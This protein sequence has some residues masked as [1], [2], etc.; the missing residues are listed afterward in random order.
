M[1]DTQYV[2]PDL[3]TS[4]ASSEFKSK[5]RKKIMKIAIPVKTDKENPAIAPLFGKAKWFAF[6]ED[7]NVNI[8]KSPIQEG[9]AAIEWLI[10]EGVDTIIMQ[11]MGSG[12]YSM[13]RAH[14]GI[15]LYHSGYE[16]IT[17]DLVLKKFADNALIKLDET[18]IDEIIAHHEGKHSHGDQHHHGE[19]HTHEHHHH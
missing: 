4:T 16:R 15:K 14:G 7:N 9:R 13:I 1:S 8:M 6:I 10:R 12:P 17:L 5:K 11:E 3:P 18:N 2:N 19:G